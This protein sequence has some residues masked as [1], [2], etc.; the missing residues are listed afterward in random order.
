MLPRDPT[1][2]GS[3]S[4]SQLWQL[5]PMRLGFRRAEG[6]RSRGG[7]TAPGKEV[8][9]SCHAGKEVGRRRSRGRAPARRPQIDGES[10]STRM[11]SGGG[12]AGRGVDD[13]RGPMAARPIHLRVRWRASPR[14]GGVGSWAAP[15]RQPRRTRVREGG[16][17]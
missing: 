8:G 13:S 10:N 2:C 16:P 5:S 9:M 17:R 4:A 6:M 14:S 3:P 15:F 12:A 11:T 1:A 7:A